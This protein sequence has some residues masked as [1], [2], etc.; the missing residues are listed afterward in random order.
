MNKY[1]YNSDLSL[2]EKVLIGIVRAAE[3]FKRAHSNIFGN[4][5]LSFP[6]YNILRVLEGSEKG[7]SRITQVSRIMLVPNANMTGIAKRLEKKGFLIRKSDPTDERVT[8]LEITPKGRQALKNAMKE[9]D[10]W[11]EI[12]LEGFSQ[13]EKHALLDF[14]KRLIANEC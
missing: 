1:T 9:K 8:I 11:L 5:G 13:A 10:R 3:I 12:S 2:D 4:H 7:Q 14:I 6:Q